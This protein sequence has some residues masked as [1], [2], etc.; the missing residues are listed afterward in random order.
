MTDE[1]LLQIEKKHEEYQP[2]AAS[3]VMN[4]IGEEQA[5]RE[6][7]KMTSVTGVTEGK[8][9]SVGSK[10]FISS[11]IPSRLPAMQALAKKVGE[12]FKSFLRSRNESYELI[13]KATDDLYKSKF[14]NRISRIN[15]FKNKDH[16]QQLYGNLVI[17]EQVGE[18]SVNNIRLKDKVEIE[19]LFKAGKISKEEKAFY[20]VFTSITSKYKSLLDGKDDRRGYIP[21]TKQSVLESYS[22]RGMLGAFMNFQSTEDK[23]RDVVLK[24]YDPIQGGVM[25]QSFKKFE[26][27]YNAV[28]TTNKDG[29]K[30]KFKAKDLT[31][32]KYRAQ[33]LLKKGINEDGTEI[34]MSSFAIETLANQAVRNRFTNQRSNKATLY[35]SM[36]LNKAIMDYT[37]SSAYASEFRDMLP[38]VQGLIS[39]YKNKGN[40]NAVK[41]LETYYRDKIIRGK[42]PTGPLGKG[43]DVAIKALNTFTVFKLL[44][45]QTAFALG[46]IVAGKYHNIKNGNT[47][48]WADGE[49]RFWGFD[50]SESGIKGWASNFKASMDFLRKIGFMEQN[51]YEDI[52]LEKQWNPITKLETLALLPM[53]LSEKWIQ[54]VQF[55]G[56][57]SE[58]E[59]NDWKNNGKMISIEK[60]SQYEDDV[61]KSQGR[62]YNFTDQRLI[63]LYS[64]GQT[65]M[66]FSKFIPTM[67]ADRFNQEEIDA[68][69]RK[70]IGSLRQ[71]KNTATEVV[72]GR[73]SYG[74]FKAYRGKLP[75]HQKIALDKAVKGMALVVLASIVGAAAGGIGDDDTKYVMDGLVMDANYSINAPK[76]AR[77]LTN[78]PAASTLRDMLN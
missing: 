77:K 51:V 58:E 23:V 8:D 43:G 41:L 48:N 46:N 6:S 64:L 54:G 27:S 71:F 61:K 78:I 60:Q 22:N 4:A 76:L 38:E 44:G 24:G 69:G 7:A 20:D 15:P 33:Q 66:M 29:N 50:G 14:D 57:L 37:H 59:W 25:T 65:F 62:G 9:L 35:P 18:G 21:H 19:K 53:T 34:K 1:R 5:R 11:N 55:L 70:N 63:S 75:D 45:F 32:L 40:V 52:N 13:K 39:Y 36:D 67:M 17:K 73:M 68:Y 74:D 42:N 72:S 26:D 47:K 16:Y 31:I 49:K 30:N 28:S 56:M 10:W 12:R 3:L 2:E